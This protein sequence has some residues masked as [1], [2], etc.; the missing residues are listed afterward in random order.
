MLRDVRALRRTRYQVPVV[1]V[2]PGVDVSRVADLAR[3][4]RVNGLCV[5]RGA[6]DD[7]IVLPRDGSLGGL[8]IAAALSGHFGTVGLTALRGR[9]FD[10]V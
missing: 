5:A 1:T 3:E 2:A 8:G 6:S 10:A 4:A 7:L 9:S